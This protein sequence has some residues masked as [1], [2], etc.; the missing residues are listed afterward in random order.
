MSHIC[1]LFLATCRW[2]PS[3]RRQGARWR[4]GRQAG[5]QQTGMVKEGQKRRKRQATLPNSFSSSSS[6]S[7]LFCFLERKERKEKKRLGTFSLQHTQARLSLMVT[8]RQTFCHHN[9]LSSSFCLFFPQRICLP[10]M[11][12]PNAHLHLPW[13]LPAWAENTS[14]RHELPLPQ[15]PGTLLSRAIARQAVIFC[16][17]W[18]GAC[19]GISFHCSTQLCSFVSNLHETG[20]TALLAQAS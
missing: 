7:P 12:T 3:R 16:L 9:A 17:R 19:L 2:C 15:N 1:I 5:R 8:V 4:R 13:Q 11:T 14:G 20:G 18:N 10:G 6:S